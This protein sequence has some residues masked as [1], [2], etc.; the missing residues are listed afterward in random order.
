MSGGVRPLLVGMTG[1]IGSGK[2]AFCN[3]LRGLGAVV[4]ESDRVAREL[5]VGDADVVAGV[6]ALL[7]DG[8][9]GRSADGSLV[10]D[11][12]AIA[13]RVFA[14]AG[15]LGELNALIHPRVAAAFGGVVERAAGDGVAVVVKE[16]AVLFESGGDAGLD[17]VVVVVAPVEERVRRA[18][19]R[20]TG[21]RAEVLQRI[22]AQWPEERL[23][24]RA[25]MVVR[26]VGDMGLLRAEAAR[27]YGELLALRGGKGV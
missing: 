11:R 27:V 17:V 16:A 15:L 13:A 5:L 18:V 9:Y 6:R 7:G 14:D 26:N 8:V 24:A 12:R 1:G 20:G 3:F 23:V 19:A 21:S 22:E 4:F 2:S 10:A 25:G